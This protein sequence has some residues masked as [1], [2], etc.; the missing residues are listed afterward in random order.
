MSAITSTSHIVNSISRGFCFECSCG[1]VFRTPEAAKSCRKC[2]S[3]C[4][5]GYCTHVVDVRT[6]EVVL[7]QEPTEEE[8][9]AARARYEA[10]LELERLTTFDYEEEEY[11]RQQDAI[12]LSH[13]DREWLPLLEQYDIQDDLMGY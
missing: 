3:Y 10:E 9:E 5:F 12:H 4:V 6:N 1:E 2:R 8:Y 11:Q 7:G 13:E